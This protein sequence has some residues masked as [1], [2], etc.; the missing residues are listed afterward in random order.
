M[1]EAPGLIGREAE[2]TQLAGMLDAAR[3]GTSGVL[4]LEGE[5]GIGKSSLLGWAVEQASDLR[6]VRSVAV[7]PELELPYGALGH[8]LRPLHRTAARLDEGQTAALG[9]V[10]AAGGIMTKTT[11]RFQPDRFAVGAAALALLAGTAE[12][13][14]LLVAMDDAHWLDQS[15]AEAL[16]FLA[17]RLLAEGIVL[18]LSKRTGEGHDALNNL[19]TL[20]LTGLEPAAATAL[21]MNGGG[22]RLSTERIQQLIKESN[23]NPLALAELPRL[24]AADELAGLV[25][26]HQPL[27]IGE[28]LTNVYASRFAQLPDGCRQAAAIVAMVSRPGLQL[29]QGALQAADLTVDELAPAEDAGLVELTA[30]GVS[31]RHPL[32]RSAAAYSVPAGWRRRAHTAVAEA[33]VDAVDV[34]EQIERAWHLAAASTGASE[35]TAAMLEDAAANAVAQSG[36]AAAVPAYERA[37]DLS[38]KQADRYRRLVEPAR[39]PT[40]PASRARRAATWTVPAR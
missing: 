29:V 39:P 33:L 36:W 20:V 3:H 7:Q 30:S 9:A 15:S 24:L 1:T 2:Q 37:A 8:L 27:P 18:L 25:P 34:N 28:R 21:L 31:F 22:P 14:P 26:A 13:G 4:V 16:A 17:R 5:P 11:Q 38:P 32:A 23:G 6:V 35:E 12:A 10:F 40:M 19:P